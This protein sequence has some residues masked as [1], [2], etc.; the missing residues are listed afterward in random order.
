MELNEQIKELVSQSVYETV[1]KSTDMYVRLGK[2]QD[3]MNRIERAGEK[4]KNISTPKNWRMD[5]AINN[6]LVLK[7]SRDDVLSPLIFETLKQLMDLLEA[8]HYSER[9]AAIIEFNNSLKK[10]DDGS[11]T[12]K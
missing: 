6:D 12:E 7:V 8:I 9:K 1:D 4:M 2:I 11:S 5:I 3:S 10:A